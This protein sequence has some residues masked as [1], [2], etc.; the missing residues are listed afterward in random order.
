MDRPLWDV[1]GV[2]AIILETGN[3]RRAKNSILQA[4]G[5]CSGLDDISFRR[6]IKEMKRNT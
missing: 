3:Q 4:L 5:I 6:K 2:R 1:A